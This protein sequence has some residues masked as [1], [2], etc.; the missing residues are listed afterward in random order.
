MSKFWIVFFHTYLN[1][2][3]SKS[4]IITTVIMCVASLVLTNINH[5]VDLFNGDDKVKVGVI[6]ESGELLAPYQAQLKKINPD[7]QLIKATDEKKAQKK[8]TDETWKGYMIV[9]LNDQ[10]L[11]QGGYRSESMADMDVPT[12]LEQGLQQ[13]KTTIASSKVGL[14]A[15]QSQ[16]LYTPVSFDKKALDKGAKTEDELNQARVLVYILLFIIYISV[17]TYGS[18]IATEVATEKSSRVMEILISSVSPVTQ[19][20][21]KI[22]GI[23]LLSLTQFVLLFLVA[24]FSMFQNNREALDAIDIQGMSASILVYGVVFFLLGYL[25]FA[26]MAAFLG[27]LVSRTEDVQQAIMPIM[28]LIVAAFVIAVQGLGTPEATFIKVTSFI[29]F[30][31]PMIMFLR[32]GLLTIP[33]WEVM[34]GMAILVVTIIALALFGARVYRGGVLM[35]DKHSF[36]KGIKKAVQLTKNQ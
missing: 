7:I 33:V 28:I 8:V 12:D 19:M 2:L 11:P 13:L 26:T 3:K 35:Y 27:S 5:I 16:L 10:G 23:A 25:L 15:E 17:I 24:G 14:T 30:F 32:V 18:M 6:D 22:L 21:A 1:K 4:F 31:T 20:F 34:I 36:F 29:P 9:S